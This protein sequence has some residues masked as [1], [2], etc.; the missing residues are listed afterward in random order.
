MLTLK[1]V[2][3]GDH[4][5]LVAHYE[6]QHT[7]P[8]AHA[9]TLKLDVEVCQQLRFG[10]VEARAVLAP[11]VEGSDAGDALDKLADWAERLALA[12][13]HRGRVG[14]LVPTFSN[15]KSAP[16]SGSFVPEAKD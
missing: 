7:N 6:A 16:A 11:V 15:P 1:S 5:A 14:V 2:S 3:T 8:G 12:I 13:R 4:D 9:T 10:R